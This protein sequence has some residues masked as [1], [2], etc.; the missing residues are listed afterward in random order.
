MCA[1]YRIP[2]SVFLG[3]DVADRDKACWQWLRDRQTCPHCGT[4]PDEWD[5]QAGGHRR[6][7]VAEFIQCEGCVVKLKAEDDPQM[8]E[9]R[10]IRV[11]LVKTDSL[12]DGV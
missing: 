5:E 11:Q 2:H 10:G 8:Q 4:R 1:A 12:G 6:A 7:Y 9:F 3:W